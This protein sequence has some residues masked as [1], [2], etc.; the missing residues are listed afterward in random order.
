V[1]VRASRT[2]TQESQAGLVPDP[3]VGDPYDFV[4]TGTLSLPRALKRRT[5]GAG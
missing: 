2:R 5:E 1:P 4:S 3:P